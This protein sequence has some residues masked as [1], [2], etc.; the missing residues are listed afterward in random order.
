VALDQFLI[1]PMTEGLRTDVEPWLIPEEA[2][3]EL[4]NAYV[5]RGRLRKRFGTQLIPTTTLGDG[6]EQLSS[7]LRAPMSN[8]VALAGGSGV[9]T[10]DG[11]GD[12]TGTAPGATFFIGQKFLINTTV[13][14]IVTLTPAGPAAAMAQNG[15]AATTA[16][17]DTSTGDYAF[18]GATINTQ[19]YF[20]DFI[21]AATTDGAGAATGLVPGNVF[22]VGQS[23]SIYKAAPAVGEVTNEILTA[24]TTGAT[25]AMLATSAPGGTTAATFS[26]TTGE[27]VITGAAINAVLHFYPSQP[28]MGFLNYEDSPINLEPTYAF[29]TQFAYHFATG[30]WE[31]LGN[32]V[33]TGTDSQFFWGHNYRGANSFDT[34]LFVTNNNND[35]HLRYWSGAAWTTI[36]PQ[37]TTTAGDRVEGCRIVVAFK[38]RLLLLNTVERVNATGVT[39]NHPNR[40]RFSQNGSPVESDA[41]YQP[42]ET[43]G[44][45]GW[46]D[47]P[48]KEAI[49]SAKTLRDRLVVFFER[50]TWELAYTGNRILPFVWQ[51]I[52]SELGAESTFSTVLFDKVLLG[53]GNVGI[54]ACNGANVERIDNKIPEAV[55]K[56]HNGSDGVERVYGIR[57]YFAETVYWTLPAHTNDPTYPTRVLVYNY[58]NK[59]WALNDDS[60]TCF[61][62]IQNL[63]D[64][65][66]NIA[67]EEWQSRLDTWDSGVEQ[68]GFRKVIGG[69]QQGYTFI[70]DI[71]EPR[72]A[73]VLQITQMAN[74]SGAVTITAINHNM[75]PGDYVLIENVQ[76]TSGV[77]GIYEIQSIAAGPPTTFVI[78]EPAFTGAYTGG[79]TV[80]RVSKIDIKTKAYNFYQKSGKNLL[81]PKIAF[82]VGRTSAGKIS[83][84]YFASSS[85]RSLVTDGITSGAILGTSVLETMPYGDVPFESSQ[86]R[87]WHVLYPQAEG[88]SIQFRLYFS[89]AQMEVKDAAKNVTLLDFQLN[90]MNIYARQVHRY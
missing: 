18:T 81:I 25:Q 58:I 40:C 48:T 54:H 10:T 27:Y 55:F 38:D 77:D 33:W 19:I 3:A 16:T 82:Y 52:N 50:S 24:V 4:K 5:W 32:A 59:T 47:A 7:R 84:D 15:P 8:Q 79:G 56:I 20:Y 51:R 75:Q 28:V 14:T 34:L 17:F 36:Q 80:A 85:N 57:D 60:I 69:N 42:T 41:W 61:G 45:G 2:F 64:E 13:F 46:I 70:V 53:V 21:T 72:N 90:A 23:F 49:I 35:D 22:E 65:T 39:S 66:W 73:P 29:D 62:Y 26:T 74:A 43:I 12:A 86:D 87:F 37:Y 30:G 44:K 88:E 9:G 63:N 89:D 78:N 71:D 31:R 76:G 68:S 6:Y 1:A 11:V 83:V 67:H